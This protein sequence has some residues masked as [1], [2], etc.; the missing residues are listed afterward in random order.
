ML[1]RCVNEALKLGGVGGD[2]GGCAG[3]GELLKG[4]AAFGGSVKSLTVGDD[5][6]GGFCGEDFWRACSIR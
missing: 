5:D 3:I 2:Y 6:A 1:R 4:N